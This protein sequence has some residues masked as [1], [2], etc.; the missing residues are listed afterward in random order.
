MSFR[1]EDRKSASPSPSRSAEEGCILLLHSRTLDREC[2]V[3]SLVAHGLR[4]PILAHGTVQEWREYPPQK[5][6]VKVVVMDTGARRFDDAGL[7]E[8]LAAVRA[9]TEAPVLILSQV[10][11]VQHLLW[12]LDNGCRMF[13][14]STVSVA[15]L[16]EAIKVALVG[17]GFVAS[18]AFLASLRPQDLLKPR[19]RRLDDMFSPRQREV[20][21]ALMRGKA[22]KIIAYELSLQESTVKVHVREIMRKLK[23]TNRTQ[24][25]H[26][27]NEILS[28]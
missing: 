26:R 6:P 4:L 27:L 25:V 24:A 14:P 18:R 20:A 22:N 1:A 8:E 19:S 13:V 15:V 10:E 16:A 11:D 7:A 9:A 17:G 21:E 23:A 5:H 3:M 2:L 12:L 28:R